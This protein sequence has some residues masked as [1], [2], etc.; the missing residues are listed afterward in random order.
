MAFNEPTPFMTDDL[1]T[2]RLPRDSVTRVIG[3]PQV[4]GLCGDKASYAR[5]TA[6][7]NSAMKGLAS[8]STPSMMDGGANICITGL[9]EL[10]VDVEPTSEVASC[11]ILP[12]KCA[13][14]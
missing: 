13:N 1:I 12:L 2:H 10:L 9:L 4:F 11:P 3:L 5:I 7:V 8:G 6:R 14:S